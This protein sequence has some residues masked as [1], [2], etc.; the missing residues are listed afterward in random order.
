MCRVGYLLIGNCVRFFM[1]SNQGIYSICSR[2]ND[3]SASGWGMGWL[4]KYLNNIHVHMYEVSSIKNANLSIQYEG[5]KLQKCLIASK[6]CIDVVVR[7]QY[8]EI[9]WLENPIFQWQLSRTGLGVRTTETL[10]TRTAWRPLSA[11]ASL[12]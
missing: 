8:S 1:T 12:L 7:F 3:A 6:K 2:R 5:I 9:R 4:L 11:I 10:K